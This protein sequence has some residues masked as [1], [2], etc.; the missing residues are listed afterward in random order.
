M[1]ANDENTKREDDR[2]AWEAAIA[3]A[4]EKKNASV[5]PTANAPKTPGKEEKKVSIAPSPTK[6]KHWPEIIKAYE[7]YCKYH[8]V[9]ANSNGDLV[10][11]NHKEAVQFF[12]NQAELGH[13]FFVK[14][15][16]DGK[17]VNFYMLSCGDKHLYKG[18]IE[19]IQKELKENIKKLEEASRKEP[20]NAELQERLTALNEG[21][22]TI[23][24]EMAAEN[25]SKMR[26][27]LQGHRKEADED[28]KS[29][30]PR[31]GR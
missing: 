16:V 3:A 14:E 18:K 25:A 24:K 26:E 23:N 8:N 12:K 1:P 21:L 28:S 29:S 17:P 11:E 27:Q 2:K 5:I 10:F 6:K 20:E 13:S 22:E 7:D 19:D 30:S 15:L 31:P 9:K 4:E